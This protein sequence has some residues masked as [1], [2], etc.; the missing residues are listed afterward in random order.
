M[1]AKIPD[2]AVNA[3]EDLPLTEAAD[4][5]NALIE[6]GHTIFQK[7]TCE[8]CGQRLTM[9]KPNTFY[10]T[11]SC[12]QCGHV[13]TIKYCGLLTVMETRT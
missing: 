9:D 5:A 7:F 13:T 10:R 2:G 6:Q 4:M 12:D 8:E 3:T 11:G 1:A